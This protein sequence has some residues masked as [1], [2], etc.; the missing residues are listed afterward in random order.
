MKDC[1]QLLTKGDITETKAVIGQMLSRIY[2]TMLFQTIAI[3][4]LVVGLL[5][6]LS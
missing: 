3:V 1:D 6:L 5:K 4:G 2:R